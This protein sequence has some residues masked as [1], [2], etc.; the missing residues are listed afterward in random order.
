MSR[1]HN[2]ETNQPIQSWSEFQ[3]VARQTAGL[4]HA[5]DDPGR[6]F[7]STTELTDPNISAEPV[8]ADGR[9][10]PKDI[11][12]HM[13]QIMERVKAKN[14]LADTALQAAQDER[15]D[16]WAS[17]GG[18]HNTYHQ[19]G[20]LPTGREED[21]TVTL[22]RTRKGQLVH[23]VKLAGHFIDVQV[24]EHRPNSNQIEAAKKSLVRGGGTLESRLTPKNKKK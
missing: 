21:A 24:D 3:D 20:F 9:E 1:P 7:E 16:P 11:Y 8:S 18:G 2:P 23:R 17:M 13:D 12:S 22:A 4:D 14:A 6:P 15:E 19:E 5:V 10:V